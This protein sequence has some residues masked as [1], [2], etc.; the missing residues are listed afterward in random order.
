MSSAFG[1]T[2]AVPQNGGGLPPGRAPAGL[3]DAEA[4][5]LA[6]ARRWITPHS[7]IAR[8]AGPRAVK[9]PWQ[10]PAPPA[11]GVTKGNDV[12]FPASTLARKGAYELAD[13][14]RK[15]GLRVQLGGPVIED[16]DCWRG[17]ET[18]PA[19][20]DWAGVGVVALP[21]WVEHQPRALLR[22]L[23]AGLPVIA[24]EGC[25]LDG[26]SGANIIPEGDTTA[27]EEALGS[28]LQIQP[29]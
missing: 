29:M 8:M 15:L 25:G 18:A 26:V 9:L 27:L 3:A 16:A 17:I 12:L 19:A 11:H 6:E 14:A 1:R 22:A 23:A 4:A 24:A 20:P 28:Q 2:F 13:V 21:G 7:T 10:F 5:A